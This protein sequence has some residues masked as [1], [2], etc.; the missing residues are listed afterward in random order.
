MTNSVINSSGKKYPN[1]YVIGVAGGSGSGKTTFV[2]ALASR[3]PVGKS[4][5][6][7][8]DWYY[9]SVP[10]LSYEERCKLNYDHPE[11]LDGELLYQHLVALRAGQQV[12]TPRY[13]FATHTRENEEVLFEPT[14]LI[15]VEGILTFAFPNLRELLDLKIF[16]YAPDDLRFER[17]M[18]RDIKERGRT[19]ESVTQQWQQTVSPMHNEFCGPSMA[20][21]DLV[22]SGNSNGMLILE[23]LVAHLLG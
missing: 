8:F 20:H 10:D 14:P 3:L 6:I 19:P 21:A 12:M 7:P 13:D 5:I 23:P 4:S 9:R 15:L 2:R 18:S 16:I 1:P 17:R 11:A 22:I